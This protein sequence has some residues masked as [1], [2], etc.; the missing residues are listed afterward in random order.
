[1]WPELAEKELEPCL[2]RGWWEAEDPGYRVK[3]D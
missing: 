1:M 3:G 2:K